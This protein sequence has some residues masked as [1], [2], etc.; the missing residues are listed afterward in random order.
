V[1]GALVGPHQGQAPAPLPVQADEPP[2]GAPRR[3][4]DKDPDLYRKVAEELPGVLAWA[5]RG[6]LEWQRGGLE[7]QRGGLGEPAAVV[8]ATAGYRDQ[9]D[10]L[11]LVLEDRCETGTQYSE[12]ATEL[13]LAYKGWCE[14]TGERVE[15]QRRFGERLGERGHVEGPKHPVTRRTT[16]LGLRLRPLP[17]EAE[18]GPPQPPGDRP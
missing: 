18:P 2:R 4:L 12:V 3:V 8:A 17:D 10:V 14:R 16:R 5:V 13:Y 1:E 9:M 15:S 7:W 6:C 11:A